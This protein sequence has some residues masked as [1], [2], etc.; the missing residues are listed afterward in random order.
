[1]TASVLR[2]APLPDLAPIGWRHGFRIIAAESL[3]QHRALFGSHLVIFSL[4]LW[5]ALHLATA[6]YTFTPLASAPGLADRWP[7]AAD[8]RAIVLFF[9]TGALGYTFFYSL[10]ASAWHF[11]YER[12]QGTLELLFLTPASRLLLV[13]A[14]SGMALLQSTW[15]FLSFTIGIFA[16]V[17]G[18]RLAHPAMLGVAFLAL[19]V[20]A[21]AWGTFLNSLFLFSRDAAFLYT[22]FQEPME[23][24]AGSRI[25]L[26]AMPGW[27]QIVGIL[28][29]LTASLAVLRGT[30]LEARALPDVV[31]ELLILAVLSSLLLLASAWLLR[32]G[33]E[34]ARRTGSLVLF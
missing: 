22:I 14:N 24:F 23:F 26:F 15:L 12:Q 28:L 1:M 13:L 7:L 27:A 32:V 2:P 29:P 31:T 30:L 34:R 25:P 11:S 18:L 21:V 16:L 3:K 8:P 20:P 9:A 17:G 10:V 19:L 33:E 6:Y 4:M 5:P